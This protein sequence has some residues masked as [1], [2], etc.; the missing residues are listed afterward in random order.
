AP[1][2]AVGPPRGI[3]GQAR[4][5]SRLINNF[6]GPDRP[7]S[8]TGGDPLFGSGTAAPKRP[9]VIEVRPR[10]ASTPARRTL[11]PCAV[12]PFPADLI[13]NA[14]PQAPAASKPSIRP[15]AQRR[16]TAKCAG[17]RP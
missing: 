8:V 4:S 1:P 17:G 2:P 3:T 5:F 6:V 16:K 10:S 14:S 15:A 13:L 11:W 7:S 9:H 12:R